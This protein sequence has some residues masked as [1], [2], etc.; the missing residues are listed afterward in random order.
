MTAISHGDIGWLG[1][2]L[3]QDDRAVRRLVRINLGCACPETVFERIER[4]FR[5]Q[6]T[7]ERPYRLR[8]V[9]GD[10]LLIYLLGAPDPVTSQLRL[11]DVIA[12]G[13]YDRD[14]HGYNRFRAVLSGITD[15][16]RR[17]ALEAEWLRLADGDE[18]LHLHLMDAEELERV[19]TDPQSGI[20]QTRVVD[21]TGPG[22]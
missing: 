5:R 4:S 12:A 10:R 1:R 8:L 20:A 2:Q 19:V 18:H 17:A 15:P 22:P 6:P 16:A 9:I 14:V 11:A 3:M 7:R 13:R 21:V